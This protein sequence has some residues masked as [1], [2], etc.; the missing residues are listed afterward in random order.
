MLYWS[1]PRSRTGCKQQSGFRVANGLACVDSADNNIYALNAATG[2]RQ[3]SYATGGFSDSSP[4]VANGLVY[5]GSLDARVY[6]FGRSNSM[7][8]GVRRPNPA[9]LHPDS[10]R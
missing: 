7:A 5:V 1:A 2:T 6:A 4:A 10:A 8:D 3:W 9:A